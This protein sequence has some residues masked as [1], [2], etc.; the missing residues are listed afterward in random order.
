[1]RQ[2]E[3]QKE[4]KEMADTG[5][6]AFPSRQNLPWEEKNKCRFPVW[7]QEVR[8]RP[9]VHTFPA[10]VIPLSKEFQA[11]LKQDSVIAPRPTIWPIDA[12]DPRVVVYGR[13]GDRDDAKSDDSLE[14]LQQAEEERR[15]TRCPRDSNGNYNY[16]G[17]GLSD[18]KSDAT[19]SDEDS[20]EGSENQCQRGP[21][22]FPELEK[23]I[24]QA[25]DKLGPCFAKLDWTSC[26]VSWLHSFFFVCLRMYVY[27]LSC[28]FS[29]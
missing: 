24:Q 5:D 29:Y 26:K 11:F 21:Q 7:Y 6:T 28:I 23:S 25:L 3:K 2:A 27:C 13:H 16:N 19:A 4:R 22:S 10:T 8:K 18:K 15:Q 14:S 17:N 12:C 20:E 9:D 1:M